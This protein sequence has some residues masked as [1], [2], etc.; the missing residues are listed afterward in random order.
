MHTVDIDWPLLSA[1]LAALVVALIISALLIIASGYFRDRMA[2]DYR[3]NN[4]NFLE[5]SRKYLSV[6]QDELII[7]ELY[8]RFVSL[9]RRGIVGE[10]RRLDW[11]EILNNAA[12]TLKLPG[13]RYE[14]T[15]RG[16]YSPAFPLVPGP[17]QINT[18]TMKLELGLLHEHDLASLLQDLDEKA[19]GIYTVKECKLKR[20]Q[21]VVAENPDEENV[22]AECD[23]LWF[24]LSLASGERINL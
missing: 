7:K 6:D 2:E 20:A 12:A 23:L 1:P 14:I 22:K 17:Y 15:S 3:L 11:V 19:P 8:P 5:V 24:T 4:Q 21:N 18:S 9:Y 10:E 16:A 13:L